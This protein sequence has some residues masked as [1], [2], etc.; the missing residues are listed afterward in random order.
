MRRRV[1]AGLGLGLMCAPLAG[2]APAGG[3]ALEVP[4]ACDMGRACQIQSYVDR[5][6]GAAAKDYRCGLRT[7]DG[8]NGV[9]FRVPDMA[10]QRRGVDVLAAAAGRVTRLRDGVPDISFR[11]PGAPPVAGRE[12]GNAVVI[13]HGGGWE[14]QYCHLARG[15]LRVKSGQAVRA[16]EPI[17][18]VGLSGMTEFPHL[19]LRLSRQGAVVDP[20]GA[21]PGCGDQAGPGHWTPAA[22]ARLAYRTGLV[23]NAG[24]AAAPVVMGDV[25][26]GGMTVPD[27]R[28]PNLLAY[29]RMIGLQKGDQLALTLTGP[30]G[31]VLAQSRT[32]PMDRDK[33]Q[34]LAYAGKRRTAPSWP[35]GTYRARVQV[36]RG[37]KAVSERPF[38]LTIGG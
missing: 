38:A 14:T 6:P 22:A 15:S 11:A 29:A 8:H 5:D 10:A 34:Y 1:L 7:Y 3:P 37:G 31:A 12:C 33:A 16:G 24:F 20:F 25:E 9:D 2:A 36:L 21:G 28:S 23:L 26:A 17:A 30:G 35:A 32:A 13:D 27:A 4:I 18:R 19:H